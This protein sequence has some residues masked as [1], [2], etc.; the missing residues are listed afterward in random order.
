[1]DEYE[2]SVFVN[3]RSNHRNSNIA[4]STLYYDEIRFIHVIYCTYVLSV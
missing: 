3:I 4:I 2:T 1:M